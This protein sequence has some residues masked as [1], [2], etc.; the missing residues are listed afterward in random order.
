VILLTQVLRTLSVLPR[1][2]PSAAAFSWRNSVACVTTTPPALGPRCRD[3]DYSSYHW[4][5]LRQVQV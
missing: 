3:R 2:G 5:V 1:R 4:P